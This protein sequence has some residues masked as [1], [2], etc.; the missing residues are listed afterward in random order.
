MLGLTLALREEKDFKELLQRIEYGGCPLVYSGLQRVHAAH[1]AAAVRKATG[2]PVAVICPD[3]LEAEQLRA[4]LAALTEEEVLGLT[5]REFTFFQADSVS[6]ESEHARLRVFCRLLE[7]TVGL[8]TLTP[9]SLMQR[10]IPP[11]RLKA[12]AFTLRVGDRA[13]LDLL[14]E[15]L[16]LCGYKSCEAV[17]GTGQFAIRGGILDFFSPVYPQPVR[18]E[19]FGDEI[20]AM[21]LFDTGTQRRTENLQRAE[22]LPAG[23]CLPC[24][25]EG[26]TDLFCEKLNALVKRLHR[27][28]SPPAALI[29]NLTAD[30]ERVGNGLGFTAADKYFSLIYDE[31]ADG[32]SYLPEDAV[33]LFYEPSRCGEKAKNRSWQLG[34]DVTALLEAQQLESSLNAYFR[35]WEEICAHLADWP[36]IFTDS[37]R[38][39]TYPLA[40]R[41]LLNL[42]AKQLS[43]YGGSLSTA[44]GDIVHYLQEGYRLVVFA[45]DRRKAE[46]LKEYLE[47]TGVRPVIDEAL[48]KLGE[49]GVCVI[50]VGGLSAGMEYPGM[51]LAVLT[52]GQFAARFT[53][54]KA[55]KKGDGRR[56]RI[57]SFTDLSKG[58]LVVHETHGIG[59]FLGVERLQVDGVSKDYVKIGYAGTDV[60]YVPAT[61]LDVV[62]KYIGAGGEDAP[63]KLSKLGGTDWAKAK[64]RAKKAAQDLAAGLIKLYAER[65]RLPGHAFG[66]DTV[67]QQEFEERFEYAETEDQLRAI[68]EI[69]ADMEKPVP[70]DRLLCGDVGFGKTEVALRAVMKCVMDGKQAA[71]LV[72][73]TVLAQQHYVTAMK[74]F[75]GLPVHIEVLSRFRSQA[76]IKSALKQVKNGG[77]DIVIGTHR[78]LQKDV[79]FRDLGLLVVDEEQRFGVTHKERLKEMS[80]GV[81]CLTLSATPIP[82]TLNMALAGIRDMSTIEEPPAGRHPVQTYVLEHDWSVLAD[83]IRRELG[84][85]GQVYYLHNRVETIDRCAARIAQMVE[86]AG[87]AVAH[88]K[89]DEGALNAVMDRVISGEVQVLVCTTIIETGID[90]PNVNTLII[91]DAD[92]LGL[93]QLHQIR[94]RV[95]R[96]SRH[97]FAYF[98]F[99]QGKVLTEVA[100]KRLSAIREYA[101]FNSGFRI[102]MRDLEIRGA[103]NLLGAEQSGHMMSVG[104]D[105]YLKLLEE[106]VL[107]QKGE[108]KKKRAEC[109]ADLSVEAGI[110]DSYVESPE[111]RMD[112]YRRIALIQNEEDADDM[113]DELIDRFGD[114]PRSVNNLIYVALMR[115]EAAEA[116][117]T[118]IT[119]KSGRLLYKLANFDMAVISALYNMEEYRGR[120]RVEAGSNPCV[121]L[122][123]NPGA[124]VIRQ[125][126][127]FIRSYKAVQHSEGQ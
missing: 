78:L 11:A 24:L 89:M 107:E 60:L 70:M 101:E 126:V 97:A 8:L 92:R 28:K 38:G 100:N 95:G 49:P 15:K 14:A 86:G 9:D 111:Q 62:S 52:E 98:T 54:G 123:L 26:G 50:A 36:V 81:D 102:A 72:P 85:G 117:I 93:A 122:K 103:G 4:D 22:V 116:G 119:Q 67:W 74:R 6:R 25:G 19:L 105:M 48:A 10:T 20:D 1:A 87:V 57:Q 40:P 55:R 96:S 80:R 44:A 41:S 63:V 37:F 94:G 45:G 75:A 42:T 35:D 82:R 84:R 91:E 34:Q 59:R 121:G 115:G 33:V 124:D 73:T 18:C 27:R 110:P 56:Q 114:P 109:S 125:S 2:R 76:Q 21:G 71:I 108:T 30:L 58:D 68:A 79:V 127:K 23:E 99:R 32:V 66:P 31:F 77:A 53:Q 61:Q 106:A 39:S 3:E 13:D 90:I 12:A 17:E 120:L 112:L 113:T 104:F 46:I 29:A 64:T 69:K 7:G 51:K 65:A 47:K 83:A 88:G 16:V 43:S 5:A 118:E